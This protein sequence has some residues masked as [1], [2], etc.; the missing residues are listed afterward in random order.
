MVIMKQIMLNLP[1]NFSSIIVKQ[2]TINSY[3]Y[4]ILTSTNSQAWQLAQ[5]KI[6][7]PFIVIAKQQTAGK[8]QRGNIWRSPMGGL[9][10]S[11]ALELN[12]SVKYISHLTLF[13]VYGIVTELR[14]FDIPVKIKWLNDLILEGKK[15]GGILCEIRS[16]G[17]MIKTVVIGVGINYQ[18]EICDNGISLKTY[19]DKISNRNLPPINLLIENV[20]IGILSGYEN[21]LNFGIDSIVNEYNNLMYNLQEKVIIE[22]LKGTILGINN[23]GNLQIKITSLGASSKIRFSPQNY[24]L[25]Y[26]KSTDGYYQLKEKVDS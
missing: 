9:Y 24:S 17:T 6:K 1:E 11:M 8:G 13:T 26:N 4:E 2:N 20:I 22:E 7:L 10:L 19:F 3:V 12:L 14:K 23:Q 25:S 21:Y 16:D 15:L 5:E 18:N